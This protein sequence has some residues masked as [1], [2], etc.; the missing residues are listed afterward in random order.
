[1]SR[2]ENMIKDLE[3]DGVSGEFSEQPVTR[4]ELAEILTEISSMITP[5]KLADLTGEIG[6]K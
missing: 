6:E 3:D 1:M 4:A 2:L 5:V